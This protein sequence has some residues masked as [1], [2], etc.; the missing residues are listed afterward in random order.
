MSFWQT[1]E[2]TL[3]QLRHFVVLADQG[4]FVQA[5]AALFVTQPALSR[6]I[7]A[8]EDELGGA[9]FDR[10]GRRIALTPFGREVLK[11]ARRLVSDA[12]DLKMVGSGLHAGLIGRLRIGLSSAPGA[13]FSTPLMQHMAER[14][15]R[16]QVHVSRGST[17]VLIHELREQRLDAAI[18]DIR[19]MTPSSDLALAHVFDLRA[20][21]L[22][23]PEHPLAL[24]GGDVS[25][26]RMKAYPMASTPLSDEVARMLVTDYGPEANPDDLITLRCDETLN[27][28]ELARRADVIVLTVKAVAGDL[29]AL[30]VQPP[31]RATA[32]F[33]LVS[34][35]GRHE[36]PAL[37][38]VR[39]WLASW[40]REL[41]ATA[42]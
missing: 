32:R 10:L 35:S 41:A 39:D 21:F 18:V 17:A 20:G 23:R 11:R 4:S 40:A 30:D 26:Q 8:L 12:E 16:L 24:A 14:H 31:L 5:S 38:P 2:M 9:L 25:L 19:S 29:V 28:L 33:G 42:G 27:L 6:S 36:A 1:S 22:V 15:P 3:V 34:L 37:Q 7:Q 13:L